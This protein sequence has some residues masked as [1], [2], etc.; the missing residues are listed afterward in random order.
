MLGDDR[1]SSVDDLIEKMQMNSIDSTNRLTAKTLETMGILALEDQAGDI[2]VKPRVDDN[3]FTHQLSRLNKNEKW[4][5][6]AI[7]LHCEDYIHLLEEHRNP[8][9]ALCLFAK[10][11]ILNFKI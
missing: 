11:K 5:Q 10:V 4:K 2:A 3:D 9:K 8:T 6:L 7:A 1:C